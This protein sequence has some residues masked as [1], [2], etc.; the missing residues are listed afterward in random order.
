M[1]AQLAAAVAICPPLATLV[2]MR[3]ELRML[4]TSTGASVEALV[5]DLRTWLL[6]AEG[7][8]H[9]CASRVRHSPAFRSCMTHRNGALQG[10]LRQEPVLYGDGGRRLSP[11][12]RSQTAAD[13][14]M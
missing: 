3:E 4:W 13:A 7:Q 1:K 9:R 8:R 14:S 11:E 2:T 5:A 6:K 10:G 12:G